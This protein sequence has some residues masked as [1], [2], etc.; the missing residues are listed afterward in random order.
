MNRV[1]KVLGSV[2]D[3]VPDEVIDRLACLVAVVQRLAVVFLCLIP[4][5]LLADTSFEWVA[6]GFL[7]L[8]LWPLGLAV[9]WLLRAILPSRVRARLGGLARARSAGQARARGLTGSS[10]PHHVVQSGQ[11]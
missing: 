10:L 2:V 6:L 7:V 3:R 11:S 1:E 4:V 9:L 5:A 8:A